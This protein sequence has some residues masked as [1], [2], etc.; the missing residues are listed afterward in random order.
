[1][2][3][4][5]TI[6]YFIISCPDDTNFQKNL[7]RISPKKKISIL[8]QKLIKVKSIKNYLV[9]D[10]KFNDSLGNK[11]V[12]L[13]KAKIFFEESEIPIIIKLKYLEKIL[14]SITPIKINKFDKKFIY[15]ISYKHDSFLDKLVGDDEIYDFINNK[16][17]ISY[18][19]KFI[20]FKEY[21]LNYSNSNLINYLLKDTEQTINELK[22]TINYEF[23]L[24][25]FDTLL[26]ENDIYNSMSLNDNIIKIFNSIFH[27]FIDKKEIIIKNNNLNNEKYNQIIKIIENYRNSLKNSPIIYNIDLFILIF[28]QFNDKNQFNELYNRIESK[29]KATEYIISHPEIFKLDCSNLECLFEN[30]GKIE[31]DKIISLAINFN[32]YIKFFLSKKNFIPKK[33]SLK[34]Y[35][36]PN[37]NIELKNIKKLIELLLLREDIKFPSLMFI[38]IISLLKLR[39]YH[40]LIEL[41]EIFNNYSKNREFEDIL[42]ELIKVI[43]YTGKLFIEKD[44]LSN[45]EIISFIQV[46]GNVFDEEYK[47][48]YAF[49]CLLSH[50][51]LDKIDQIFCKKFNNYNYEQLFGKNYTL[52]IDSIIQCAKSFE[53]LNVL[54]DI[55]NI[56]SNSKQNNEIIKQLIQVY[57]TKDLN[58]NSL[59]IPELSKIIEVLFKLVSDNNNY[60]LEDLIKGTEK[61]FSDKEM[62]ELFIFILNSIPH[63]LNKD[64]INS[65]IKKIYK[66]GENLSNKDIIMILNYLT[67][68]DIQI[69]FFNKLK[70]RIITNEEIFQKE[71]TNNLKLLYDLINNGFFDEK[72]KNIDFFKSTQNVIDNEIVNLANFNFS[73]QQLKM[74]YKL[75]E[76]N[77]E[78][79]LK[80]RLFILAKGDQS[81]EEALYSTLIQKINLYVKTFEKIEQI[82]NIYSIYYPNDYY[83]VIHEYKKIRESI[84]KNKINEFPNIDELD[85]FEDISQRCEELSKYKNSKF[86]IEI[87]QKN[88]LNENNDTDSNIINKTKKDFLK[89][90]KII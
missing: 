55:F 8:K 42:E 2:E 36:K 71:L 17:I 86:F 49:A 81:V 46:D 58:R 63:K 68:V 89:I 61:K 65:L 48:N 85:D 78:N 27:Y 5:S 18:L 32:E 69:S 88:K 1:M 77:D 52:F 35:P 28:Y 19:Q 82:I 41:F 30:R 53:H 73:M 44:R 26:Q 80:N 39:D 22:E 23:I 67:N 72:F 6:I 24:V 14:V 11:N 70:T 45:L 75:N 3:K 66:N 25:F 10:Q 21:I 4:E 60:C 83:K 90:K 64:L 13:Y 38:E 74:M 62:N 54:Y 79:S 76:L 12:Y 50:I 87:F 43:H 57:K 15:S 33:F 84:L 56:K 31:F 7:I 29:I 9:K 34:N 51:N 37:D 16:F 59:S 40:K 20:I 47:N